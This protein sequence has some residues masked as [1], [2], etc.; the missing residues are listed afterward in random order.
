MD[1]YDRIDTLLKE[2]KIN[3]R[4]LSMDLNIPYTTLVSM[5]NR[6]STSVDIETIKKIASY[7]GTDIDFLVF[8]DIYPTAIKTGTKIKQFRINQHM[9]QKELAIQTG[10]SVQDIQDIEDNKKSLTGDEEF[11]ISQIL[12]GSFVDFIEDSDFEETSKPIG[13]NYV[14]IW[15]NQQYSKFFLQGEQAE[16]VRALAKQFNDIYKKNE[17]ITD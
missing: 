11:N 6:R 2:K 10:Y 1:M 13:K 14:I 15:S 7:L 17:G 16:A 4:R 8:G 3:K 12:G 5:F 9:T